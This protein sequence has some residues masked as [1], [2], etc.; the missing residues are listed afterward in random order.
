MLNNTKEYPNI[1]YLNNNLNANSS[2]KGEVIVRPN[3]GGTSQMI[4]F[5]LKANNNFINFT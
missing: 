3:N 4:S 1:Y 2:A 5:I